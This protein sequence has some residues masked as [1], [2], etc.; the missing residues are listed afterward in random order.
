MLDG[1]ASQQLRG[2]GI[3]IDSDV[4]VGDFPGPSQ[5]LDFSFDAVEICGGSGVLSKALAREGLVVCT[6]I[7]ISS[8]RHFDLRDLRLI[9]WIFHMIRTGCFKS[10]VC[11]PSCT[12]LSPAQHPASR[13]YDIPLGFDRCDPKT[14]LGN[15]FAFRCLAIIWYAMRH[16]VIGL[17]EQPRL[18]KM[19]LLS[20]W[21]FLLQIGSEEAVADSCVF[22][23]IH[24]KPVRFL[25]CHMPVSEFAAKCPGG[26]AHVRVECKFTKA[27]A[28]YHPGLAKTLSCSHC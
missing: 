9:E 4:A 15:V 8:S 6:P 10:V 12:T 19:A 14:L 23:S 2:L 3:D 7:E 20:I 18:S 17:L 24:R 21:R 11:E 1:A 16:Q 26:H 13:S 5:G 27:S 22:G 28:V 25:G